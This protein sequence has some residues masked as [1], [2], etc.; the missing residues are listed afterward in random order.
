MASQCSVAAELEWI[1]FPIWLPQLCPL[2][3]SNST[4]LPEHA[5]QSSSVL[6]SGYLITGSL[7]GLKAVSNLHVQFLPIYQ[8]HSAAISHL[9]WELVW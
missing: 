8:P 1:F 2:D 3:F 6:L 5:C 9:F 4:F 7:A